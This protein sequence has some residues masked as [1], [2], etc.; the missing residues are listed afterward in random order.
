MYIQWLEM[1]PL[2]VIHVVFRFEKHKQ[3]TVGSEALGHQVLVQIGCHDQPFWHHYLPL[4]ETNGIPIKSWCQYSIT[5]CQHKLKWVHS[6]FLTRW[7]FPLKDITGLFVK[8]SD[9]DFRSESTQ[10]D[11][12]CTVEMVIAVE[13]LT[14]G[15]WVYKQGKSEGFDSCDRPSNLTQI[16][17]KSSI[18]QPVWPWNLMDEPKKQ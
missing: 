6:Y 18:F 3:P 1:N 15:S 5:I 12:L 7:V 17:F 8:G 10:R 2:M 4:Q 11:C 14:S 16:G 9:T 13:F